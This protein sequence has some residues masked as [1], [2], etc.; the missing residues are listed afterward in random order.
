M[1]KKPYS[2]YTLESWMSF[3]EFS[4]TNL[5][6]YSLAN[7]FVGAG[8]YRA[9]PRPIPVSQGVTTEATFSATPVMSHL[10]ASSES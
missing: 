4:N 6:F 2:T 7:M 10:L 5:Y 8:V 9:V 1:M 3:C